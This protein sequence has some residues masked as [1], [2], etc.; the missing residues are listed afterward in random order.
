MCVPVSTPPLIH[1][2][3]RGTTISHAGASLDV[4]SF[5]RDGNVFVVHP[6][7]NVHLADLAQGDIIGAESL[8][9]RYQARTNPKEVANEHTYPAS[10]VT[11]SRVTIYSV[12]IN[13]VSWCGNLWHLGCF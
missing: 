1:T 6:V 2:P 11:N 7:G 8:V 3:T 5:I 9:Q 4:L 13:D 10:V 12:K